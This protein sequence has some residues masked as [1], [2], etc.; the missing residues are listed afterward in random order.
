MAVIVSQ[1]MLCMD[2]HMQN[3]R[4]CSFLCIEACLGA[5]HVVIT[6]R[7]IRK[8]VHR[9]RCLIC[10]SIMAMTG[11]RIEAKVLGAAH[12]CC[13]GEDHALSSSRLHQRLKQLPHFAHK[14]SEVVLPVQLIQVATQVLQSR[15]APRHCTEDR[16]KSGFHT[17]FAGRTVPPPQQLQV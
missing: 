8:Q 6:R 16:T 17:S 1:H 13:L 11:H 9:K 12:I 2:L 5:L 14:A 4:H 7:L 10:F 3:T 15:T